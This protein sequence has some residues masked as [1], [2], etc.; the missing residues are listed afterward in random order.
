M[1]KI[2]KIIIINFYLISSINAQVIV[3]QFFTSSDIS[4]NA[5]IAKPANIV[6][7]DFLVI[8]ITFDKGSEAST[9]TQPVGQGFTLIRTTNNLNNVG[10]ATFYKIV[11]NSEPN[12]YRFTLD[13]EV[14]WCLGISVL[15]GV[16]ISSPINTHQ[17]NTNSTPNASAIAPSIDNV[18]VGTFVM[19]FYT[20]KNNVTYTNDISTTKIYDAPNDSLPSNM[21]AVFTQ[22]T[23]GPTGDKTALANSSGL[24]ASQ[25]VT[26]NAIMTELPIELLTFSAKYE[27]GKVILNWSTATEFNND[28]FTIEK[29]IDGKEFEKVLS[30]KGAGNSTIIQNY[31]T[32]DLNPYQ[33]ISYYR[34]KQTDYD[35][36]TS[37]SDLVAVKIESKVK[38]IEIFPNPLSENQNITLDIFGN[39]NE[40]V[41]I[42]AIDNL[43]RIYYSNN[44]IL[45]SEE[46]ILNISLPNGLYYIIVNINN[47]TINR[48]IIVN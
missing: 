32:E 20:H 4:R 21:L 23:T 10:I 43:G 28:Y 6:A 24:W 18:L 26:F 1:L 30:I 38:N 5:I 19:C 8:G 25:Q 48:K 34:L 36:L 2:I 14:A 3:D 46:H 44:I 31:I 17:G 7:G 45:E 12:N 40:I 13:I 11:G 16:D 35:G 42:K 27:E 9:I 15:K 39:K 41:D 33:G 29:S 22:P 37:F 47:N